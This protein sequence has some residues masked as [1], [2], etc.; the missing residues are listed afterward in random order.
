MELDEPAIVDAKF[1]GPKA[2]SGKDYKGVF[3]ATL[4]H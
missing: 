2:A 4:W 1:L 3:G